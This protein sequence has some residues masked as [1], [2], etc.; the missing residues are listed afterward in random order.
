MANPL[1]SIF[2]LLFILFSAVSVSAQD[3]VARRMGGD[4]RIAHAALGGARQRLLG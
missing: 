2:A 3:R 1:A 4:D